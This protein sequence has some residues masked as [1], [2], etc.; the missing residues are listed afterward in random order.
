VEVPEVSAILEVFSRLFS[1][2]IMYY[3]LWLGY[4]GWLV[5]QKTAYICI[6]ISR[7]SDNERFIRYGADL[8]NI[9]GR[10]WS[11]SLGK[12]AWIGWIYR[13]WDRDRRKWGCMVW[14]Y[15]MGL[16]DSS[17][18][19]LLRCRITLQCSRLDSGLFC[20]SRILSDLEIK[21]VRYYGFLDMTIVLKDC[22]AR[23]RL[24]GIF[25]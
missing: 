17:S 13:C 12:R 21:L 11:N 19:E 14:Q 20:C 18:V 5:L 22:T 2:G 24:Y 3:A 16:G 23:L 4:Y 25:N 10:F 7:I 9:D 15:G 6:C 1:K 8:G